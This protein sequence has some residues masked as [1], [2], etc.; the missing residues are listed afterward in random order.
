MAE[1]ESANEQAPAEKSRIPIMRA[2]A[3]AAIVI[4]GATLWHLYSEAEARVESEKTVVMQQLM[5]TAAGE[6]GSSGKLA[7]RYVDAN[8][9]LVADAPVDEDDQLAPE[10]LRFSF[11][12][13]NDV[14]VPPENWKPLTDA[15]AEA[16]G[17][18]VEIDVPLTSD[19]QFSLLRDG[20]L[21]ITAFNTG[22]VPPAVN[23]CGFI[24]VSVPADSQGTW[25]YTCKII[26]PAEST[27][28][29]PEDLRGTK[30]VFTET[31]SNSG[32]RFPLLTLARTYGLRPDLDYS[33]A[34]SGSH[35]TSIQMILDANGSDIAATVAS[36][37]LAREIADPESVRT[38]YESERFPPACFGYSHALS[39]RLA[40]AIHGVLADFSFEGTILEEE[41]A[42]T[43]TTQLVEIS[44]KDDWSAVRLVETAVSDML[45]TAPA[46]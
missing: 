22:A 10:T 23:S 41:F 24:P 33:Y 45:E 3:V 18:P 42:S 37:V 32:F 27:V 1:T 19:E 17:L 7:E 2:F 25:G 9:D 11:L 38:I 13:G 20:E 36:D 28:Q 5:D 40:E 26:V 16:T 30:L 15:L 12:S 21:H 4:T 46:P 44:F 8:M 6:G 43:G 29:K 35:I 14:G 34:L 31:V 39:P